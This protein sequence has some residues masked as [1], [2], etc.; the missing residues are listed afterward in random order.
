MQNKLR[1][2]AREFLERP[3]AGC[4][5][6]YETGARGAVQAAFIRSPEETERLIW[7]R[8]CFPNLSAYLPQFRQKEGL[9]GIAVKGCDARAL[10]E[11]IR[12]RQVDRA[13]VFVVGI[14]CTGLAGSQENTLAERCHGCIYPEEFSYDAVL[15]PMESPGLPLRPENNALTGLSPRERRETWHAEL[16][17]C[18]RCEACRKVCYGCFCPECIFESTQPRWLS[19]RQGLAEKFF[20]H[21][22]RAFH[23]AGRC[24]GCGECERACPAGVRL[25]L[26]NNS[27]RD[28][29]AELFGFKGA[30]VTEEAPPLIAFSKDDPDPFSGGKE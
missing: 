3:E 27:L 14:P 12:S 25:M 5:I 8:Y 26:L 23:L 22:V 1:E 21:S 16:E 7:N 10:R 19:R 29:A 24:I 9:T 13:K 20:F 17:K 4:F 6:G 18:I 30:G 15:G 2:I 28:G 11:L